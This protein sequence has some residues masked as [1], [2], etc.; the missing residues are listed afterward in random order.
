VKRGFKIVDAEP[1]FLEPPDLWERN[2]EEPY[3]SLT[4]VRPTAQGNRG[5]GGLRA[6]IEGLASPEV[7]QRSLVAARSARRVA[8]NPLLAKVVANPEPAE[9]LEGFDVEGID[10]GI[11]MPTHAMGIVRFDG[12]D[13][14]HSLAMCR[15]FNDYAREFVQANPDR[16]K[17]WGWLPPHDATLAAQ[18]AKRCVEKLGAVGVAMTGGAVNGNLLSDEF[19]DPLWE[20]VNDLGVPF[21][22]HG[23][24]PS[25]AL[26]DNIAHRYKDHRGMQLTGQVLGNP[27]HAQTELVELVLGGVLERFPRLTPVL[28]EVNASWL[29]WLLWRMDDKW[30]M[31]RHDLDIQLSMKPSDYFRRQVYAEIE[32]EEDVGKYAIDYLGADNILFSTDY[33]HSDSLF[34]DAVDTFLAQEGISDD[35]KRKILWDNGARLFGLA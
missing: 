2:L 26:K 20:Q 34:P 1:H 7:Q 33:P 24:P 27:F 11:L 23:P 13:P 18:E 32:P 9:F 16:L 17:F 30:E 12:L 21:G 10:V 8:T 28:M 5:E 15:V 3:R 14:H 6:S 19:F 35:D 29:P 25:L 4:K 22:L 31:N